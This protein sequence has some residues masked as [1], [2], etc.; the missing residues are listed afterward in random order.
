M[1]ADGKFMFGSSSSSSSSCTG[2]WLEERDPFSTSG[3]GLEYRYACDFSYRKLDVVVFNRPPTHL[4]PQKCEV[5]K[6]KHDRSS[7]RNEHQAW[8]RAVVTGSCRHEAVSSPLV[9]M[10]GPVRARSTRTALGFSHRAVVSGRNNKCCKVWHSEPSEG[11]WLLDRTYWCRRVSL[12]D[13]NII[14]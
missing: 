14:G 2:A 5:Y 7:T 1:A 6:Q 4:E 9:R 3:W 12:A 13:G 11:L 10:C 8:I